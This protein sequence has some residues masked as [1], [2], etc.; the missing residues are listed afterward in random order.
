M[1]CATLGL[2][3]KYWSPGKVKTRLGRDV[4]MHVAARIHRRFVASLTGKLR[5]CG[6]RRQLVATPPERR[7]DWKAAP[8]TATDR[9]ASAMDRIDDSWTIVDQGV[10]DLGERMSRWFQR[11]LTAADTPPNGR[12]VLIGGDCPQLSAARVTDAFVALRTHDLVLGPARDGGYYLIGLRGDQ[13]DPERRWTRLWQDIRWST[14]EV[15][16]RTMDVAQRIGLKATTL[17]VESDVDTKADLMRFLRSLRDDAED[18]ESTIML[19]DI[20]RWIDDP[21]PPNETSPQ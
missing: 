16:D 11:C 9:G 18:A 4:S 14:N 5:E 13:L 21:A 7:Q 12:A 2:M 6:D 17:P 8:S 20:Q 15:F 3:A 19:R 1:K 10:G